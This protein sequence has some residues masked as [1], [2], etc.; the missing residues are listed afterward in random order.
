MP[1]PGLKVTNR[2]DFDGRL[3]DIEQDFKKQLLTLVPELFNM[4]NGNFLKEI[5]GEMITSTDLFEYFK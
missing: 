3:L 2:R 1:H 5:N 4:E